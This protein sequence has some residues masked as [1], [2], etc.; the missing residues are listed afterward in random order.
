MKS[1]FCIWCQCQQ[2]A[3]TLLSLF[4]RHIWTVGSQQVSI[5]YCGHCGPGHATVRNLLYSSLDFST[6]SEIT[7]LIWL[8]NKIRHD[9]PGMQGMWGLSDTFFPVLYSSNSYMGCMSCF[10]GT[11]WSLNGLGRE[12]WWNEGVR[13]TSLLFLW[14]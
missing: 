12:F 9:F 7:S 5:L 13:L 1:T 11:T 4:Y 14:H 8:W 3:G 6:L 2:K 10:K